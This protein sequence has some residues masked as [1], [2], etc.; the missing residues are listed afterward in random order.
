[1]IQKEITK[2]GYEHNAM[3]T[4]KRQCVDHQHGRAGKRIIDDWARRHVR[5]F[6]DELK[7]G[8]TNYRTVASLSDQVAQEYRGRAIL[9]LLQNAHDALGHDIGD[10]PRQVS[11]VLNSSPKQP[12]LLIANSGRP[13][14]N[15]DFRGICELAQSPKDPNKS[16]G[17]K[18]LG[19]R[20]VLELSVCPQVWST[21]P[22]GGDIAFTFGFDP[23]VREQIAR[24]A[25][26]LFDGAAWI[27]PEFGA[28]PIVDW[29][30]E[31]V[32]EYRQRLDGV[33]LEEIAGHLS[34]YVIPRFLAETPPQVTRLLEDG[35]VTVIRLPLDRRKAGRSRKVID[36][37]REQLRALDEA[38]MVFLHHLR[39]L[40]VSIDDEHVEFKRYVGSASRSWSAAGQRER[41]VIGRLAARTTADIE[42]SFHVWRRTIGGEDQA[43]NMKGIADAVRGLPNRW[44]EVRKV[45]VAV[46]VEEDWDA[47]E[48]PDAKDRGG[49]R[50]VFVIFLPTTMRT[51]LGAHVNAPFYASLDRRHVNFTNS[52]NKLLLEHVTDLVI[53]AVADLVNGP[54]DTRRG[55]AVIDLLAQVADARAFD[56]SRPLTDQLRKRACD[57]G[58]PLHQ[59]ALILCDDGWQRPGVVRTMPFIPDDGPIGRVEWRKQVG[60]TVASSAL[61]A[62]REAVE[63]LLRALGGTPD[64]TKAE[65][66]HTLARMARWVGESQTE[67]AWNDFLLSTLVILPPELVSEPRVPNADPLRT[68]R[69]LPTSDGRLLSASDNAQVFFRPRHGTDDAA[70]FVDSIPNSLKERIAFLHP[71]VKTLDATQ[72]RNTKMQKF[73]DGRF[74]RGFR[75]EDLLRNVVI[76]S[77]PELPVT[78]AS[79][80]ATACAEILGWTLKL[81]GEEE[82]ESLV[83]LLLRLPVACHDG[84]FAMKEAVFGPG[85]DDRCGDQLKTLADALPGDGLLRCALLSPDDPLWG[86]GIETGGNEAEAIVAPSHGDLFARAGVVDGLRLEACKPICFWMGGVPRLP[87]N[88]PVGIPQSAWDDWKDA[89]RGQV[90]PR[91]SGWFEYELRDV[92]AI[93]PLHRSDLGDSARTALS[94]LILASLPHWKEGWDKVAIRKTGGHHFSQSVTSPLAH[95][96]T[97]IPWLDDGPDAAQMPRQ[98]PRPLTRRW[99]VPESVIR[100]QRS[101]YRHLAPLSLELTRRLAGDE[102]LLWALEELGLNVYPT[103]DDRTGP[104]LLDALASVVRA[105]DDGIGAHDA[106]PAGGFDGLL[107]QIRHAWKHF[108]PKQELPQRFVVRTKPHKFEVRATAEIGDT[109]LPDNAAHTRSLREH[110]QPIFAIFPE[111]AR[112]EIGNR[113][114]EKGA[115][116]ASG[117]RE[118]CRADGRPVADLV[119]G[120][121]AIEETLEWLPVVLLA[122]AAYGGHNPRGPATRA[123]LKA[124]ERLRHARVV[125]CESIEVELLDASGAR[126]ARSQ[127]SAYWVS[128]D[129]TLLLNRDV[130]VSSLYERIAQ[131]SQA[132]CERQ[133]LLKD[134]RLVLGSLAQHPQPTY[135]QV[136]EALGRAEIDESAVA[137]IQVRWGGVRVLRDRIRPVVELL[138]ISDSGLDDVPNL[139]ALAAWLS[140]AMPSANENPRWS[141]EDLVASARAAGDDFEMGHNAWRVLGDEA[142]L[143]KWNGALKRLGRV[144]VGNSGAED[145]ARRHL[146]QA[147]RSL[148]ALARHV[149]LADDGREEDDQAKLFSEINEV[150]ERLNKDP[151]WSRL[152]ASW[153]RQWWEV[154]F[155]AV[156]DVL[157]ERY[158]RIPEVVEPLLC[159]FRGVSNI[160]DFNSALKGQGATLEPDPLDI[161]RGNQRR[162][163]RVLRLTWE[164]YEAWIMTEREDSGRI[165]G[166]PEVPLEPVM[167]LRDWRSK[168]ELFD[169]AKR[170]ISDESFID[171][172][173]RCTTI[174]EMRDELDISPETLEQ[175][176]EK[177]L[178]YDHEKERKHRTFEVGGVDYVVGGHET[179]GEL[180]ER[181]NDL[182]EP[183]R[184]VVGPRPQVSGSGDGKRSGDSEAHST[185]PKT[186]HLNASPYLPE[187]VGIVG[188]MHAFRFLHSRFSIDEDAWVSE[189]RTKVLPLREGE[190]DKTSD[191][192]GY[193]FRFP[194]KGE[195]WCVEVKATT[196]DSTSFDLSPGEVAA[197]TRIARMKDECWHILRVRRA[198]SEPECDWLPN[199]F[200]DAD[201]RLLIREASLTVEYTL[202]KNSGDDG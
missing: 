200:K 21:A 16:V 113:L 106:M 38:A 61:D 184:S 19:F 126:V 68:V 95:W 123:W 72:Q 202:S 107:G 26:R 178:R 91:Y 2:Y 58:H 97:T 197:A 76:K 27:D 152:S 92:K 65:W 165:L 69:F 48:D 194:H 42:R 121:R 149:A 167:Y 124:K 93:A 80:E 71:G 125:L 104:D 28:E 141:T 164:Y 12:E 101:R 53:D 56:E 198:L 66:A 174:K 188:E 75:R 168:S 52:Y 50:G 163:R 43:E 153:S 31:Q 78:H 1:M 4:E 171:A 179:Y 150:R 131:A 33:D 116:R 103:E 86:A 90:N 158:E 83:P 147:A 146:D 136:Q 176:R 55:R 108:D 49:D 89:I 82:Q 85:W 128:Q 22:P 23:D 127:P 114:H 151:D 74:V 161:A 84:W 155:C 166:I 170:V 148:R 145:Q 177:R 17:N 182:P 133:D 192:L 187:L 96:L 191:S 34:P 143:P 35:H 196:E 134:L 111:E 160:D 186:A 139:D 18:G 51:G 98:Q 10:D 201:Q 14:L 60:F 3:T 46:A 159:A 185:G 117:L 173:T 115:R 181:L 189:F 195:T 25:K 62:R 15:R 79:A 59:M 54:A 137:D 77:L 5:T 199:P 122:L 112:G 156:L 40:R 29:S 130:V 30:P 120:A 44:P 110:E 132:I 102:E 37:V 175:A 129:D 118:R 13:F 64:P 172:V 81:I 73:L 63:A 39:I 8:T 193:D 7:N 119:G 88:G 99:L 109:Y 169:R 9:E 140:E 105:L 6:F 94:N 138:G 142:C 183:R 180:F 36:S 24:V 190:T 45:G 11:F 87:D 57:R 47:L 154:P 144:T 20:S 162:L 32:K 100:E 70:D 135:T 41:V 157:R 67:P